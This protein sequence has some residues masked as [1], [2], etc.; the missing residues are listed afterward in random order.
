MRSGIE[1]RQSLK[2]TL[3]KRIERVELRVSDV[4]ASAGFYSNVAGLQ[5]IEHDESRA[6]LGDGSSSPL[7]LLDS[8]GVT[9]PAD[10]YA[11]GLFHTAFRFPTRPAL[12][13][14]LTRVVATG[15]EIGAG[16][17]LVSEALYVDDPDRN[18]VEFYWDRPVEEWPPPTESMAIPMATLPVDLESLLQEGRGSDA[19]GAP[20]PQG[21][22]IGHVHLQV[23]DLRPTTEFYVQAVGLD[24]TATLAGSA[25]FFSSRG[26]H[27]HLGANI[28]RSRHGRPAP[29]HRAG[30]ERIVFAVA[31]SAELTGL[32]ARLRDT[33]HKAEE[34][35]EGT[36]TVWDPDGIELVFRL[37][38]A[39]G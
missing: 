5:V 9:E 22:D 19:V 3:I 20:A 29:K 2:S 18:G 24:Q 36:L 30:L 16:D 21:T 25:G 35:E 33:G 1:G 37:D 10:P 38:T 7:L 8:T 11:T 4:D 32:A 13:D 34:T 39:V 15:L 12:G 31:S 26:Y 6:S 17:H 28:W 14:V 23:S 27:H